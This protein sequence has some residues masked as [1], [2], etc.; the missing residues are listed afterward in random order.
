MARKEY[1]GAGRLFGN[2]S[3]LGDATNIDASVGVEAR[4]TGVTV[5]VYLMTSAEHDSISETATTGLLN[6]AGD[7]GDALAALDGAEVDIG[8]GA[9]R[10][11]VRN[12]RSVQRPAVYDRS[13]QADKTI[14]FERAEAAYEVRLGGA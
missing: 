4:L 13:D 9:V 1:S 7:M 12:V 10:L 3:L 5:C 11:V 8:D 6:Q 2:G 14:R